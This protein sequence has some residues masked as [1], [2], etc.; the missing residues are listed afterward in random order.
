[1][2]TQRLEQMSDDGLAR[3]IAQTEGIVERRRAEDAAIAALPLAYELQQQRA[4]AAIRAVEDAH[5]ANAAALAAVQHN[6]DEWK[7]GLLEL[8]QEAP[9]P[10]EIT[11]HEAV[12]GAGI[13]R[14][15]LEQESAFKERITAHVNTLGAILEPLRAIRDRRNLPPVEIG[16]TEDDCG[17]F[18]EFVNDVSG[19]YAAYF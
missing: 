13:P 4:A 1:M 5:A 2:D 9:Q 3:F 18:W 17:R 15:Y 10:P 12:F 6:G 11:A 14:D 16:L 7:I 19:R 8:L